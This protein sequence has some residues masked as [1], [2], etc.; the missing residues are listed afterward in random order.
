MNGIHDVQ[1]VDAR[2]IGVA[3]SPRRFNHQNPAH[4]AKSGRDEPGL[5]GAARQPV[6]TASVGTAC[7]SPHP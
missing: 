4:L 2:A 3:P 7:A 1:D 5:S 6:R